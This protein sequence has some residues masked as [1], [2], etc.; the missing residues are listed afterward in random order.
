MCVEKIVDGQR[1]NHVWDG[2]QQIVADVIDSQYYEAQCYIRGTSLAAAYHYTYGAKSDYTYYVQNAHGDVVNLTDADGAMTKTYY[3]DAF[4]VE[5]GL[6]SGDINVFRYSGEYYDTETGSVYL[7]AR[8][9]NP[10]TGRFT[11]KDKN[12]S[13]IESPLSLN[14]Y[15]YCFNNPII[16]CDNS[17]NSPVLVIAVSIVAVAA[18]TYGL[19]A[20]STYAIN[21][22][23][24][25]THSYINSEAL[26][27]E[28]S[29]LITN[30]VSPLT[31][32]KECFNSCRSAAIIHTMLISKK[33]ISISH[34]SVVM[35]WEVVKELG[36]RIIYA[37]GKN[38]GGKNR[39]G[40][41]NRRKGAE[42]KGPNPDAPGK[43]KTHSDIHGGETHS[44]NA[45]GSNGMPKNHYGRR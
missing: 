25:D 21:Q 45:K 15:T 2:S 7:R 33:M 8:Y 38:K 26:F 40:N 13:E 23:A 16:Y 35:T 22:S 42:N 6:D 4:G 3:Y 36:T 43:N 37:K 44:R 29:E 19:M 20:Y 11:Q 14:L 30:V 9:Y 32:A 1:I 17:G 39:E 12:N 5:I 18:I 28:N 27:N 10:A 34:N 24:V 41:P 31:E